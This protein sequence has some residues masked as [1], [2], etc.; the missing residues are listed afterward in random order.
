MLTL[1]RERIDGA[2]F[3][4]DGVLTRTADLHE[5]AWKSVFDRVLAERGDRQPFTH[6]D[7]RAHVDGRARADGVKAFLDSRGILPD[8]ALVAEI[9]ADKNAL[10]G[11]FLDRDGAIVLPGAQA[12]LTALGNAGIGIGL[13]TA[14]RNAPRVISAAGLDDAFDARIDGHVA[15]A[16]NLRSKPAPDLPLAAARRLGVAPQRCAL[17]EDAVAGVQA[18]RAGEFAPVVG[19]G[20]G[21]DAEALI[22]AGADVTIPS[23][24]SVRLST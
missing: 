8:A 10:F 15:A 11:E 2:V 21:R 5:R 23:L 3:D 16:E 20:E 7:Y 13:F 4:M 12:L 22:E 17:F 14:S 18:G 9:A 1:D 6:A 24:A 19:V